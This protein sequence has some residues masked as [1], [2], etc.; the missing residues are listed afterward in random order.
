MIFDV[1]KDT[2]IKDALWV[3]RAGDQ[4]V[5]TCK[6]IGHETVIVQWQDFLHILGHKVNLIK[7]WFYNWLNLK[8]TNVIM[9]VSCDMECFK[10]TSADVE[11]V[12]E[13]KYT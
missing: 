9:Y 12:P 10:I 8:Q 5:I 4:N 6:C 7:L 3:S 2:S 1:N 13:L 11:D